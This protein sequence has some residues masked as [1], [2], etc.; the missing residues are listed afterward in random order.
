MIPKVFR[1]ESFVLDKVVLRRDK[2]VGEL[3][4]ASAENG[5]L[6]MAAMAKDMPKRDMQ[7]F[8]GIIAGMMG[9]TPYRKAFTYEVVESSAK[10]Y[11]LKFTRCLPAN[12]WLEMKAPDLG[13]ALECSSSDAMIKAFN[14]RMRGKSVK[15]MLKGDSVCVERFELV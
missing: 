15:N 12:M 14:P 2:L 13:Y 10:V 4:K 6:M 1:S 5:A 8:S 3:T 11:E 9:A 7:A